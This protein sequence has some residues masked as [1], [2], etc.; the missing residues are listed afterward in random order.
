MEDQFWTIQ[1]LVYFTV[2]QF[3]FKACDLKLGQDGSGVV[4]KFAVTILCVFQLYCG[5]G[6]GLD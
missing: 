3:S 4:G 5:I 1:P 6:C 2:V